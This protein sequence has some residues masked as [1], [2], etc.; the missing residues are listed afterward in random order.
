VSSLENIDVNT[1]DTTIKCAIDSDQASVAWLSQSF[2][3][4][5]N[6]VGNQIT[7]DTVIR[8]FE[9]ATL[10]VPDWEGY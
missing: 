9:N 5:L 4:G 7:Q 3:P 6:C 1:G 10:D 2:S 8:F